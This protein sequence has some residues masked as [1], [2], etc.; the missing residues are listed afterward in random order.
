MSSLMS[1]YMD[2]SGSRSSLSFLTGRLK[3]TGFKR[4][5]LN[6]NK[7][8][9]HK[10]KIGMTNDKQMHKRHSL[11]TKVDGVVLLVV[12]EEDTAAQLV[13][14]HLGHVDGRK[15]VLESCGEQLEMSVDAAAGVRSRRGE[16]VE[17]EQGL[18]HVLLLMG[19]L[20]LDEREHVVAQTV[21]DQIE[22]DG[23]S[24]RQAH[25]LHVIVERRLAEGEQVSDV[26]RTGNGD[27]VL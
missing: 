8:H 7:N 6:K 16:A 20:L 11:L 12:V 23:G 21:L 17:D 25:D 9:N 10:K 13:E 24:A 2:K 19:L 18:M 3:P 4:I 5:L 14:L 26:E 15:H 22:V 1:W 27:E